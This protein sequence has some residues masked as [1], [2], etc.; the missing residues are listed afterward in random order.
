VTPGSSA[1]GSGALVTVAAS[2][3]VITRSLLVRN[4]LTETA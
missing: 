2:A 4:F 3:L 1:S